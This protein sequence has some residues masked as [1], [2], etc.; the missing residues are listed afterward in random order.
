MVIRTPYRVLH[1]CSLAPH[2]HLNFCAP[3]SLIVKYYRL[4]SPL[5]YASIVTKLLTPLHLLYPSFPIFPISS[6]LTSS[7]SLI[8]KRPTPCALSPHLL[9]CTQI[10]TR[11]NGSITS[12]GGS[13]TA[14]CQKHKQNR[15][16]APRR[17]GRIHLP[18]P[19][20]PKQILTLL[21][22]TQPSLQLQGKIINQ[23]RSWRPLRYQTLSQ[24]KSRNHGNHL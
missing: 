9:V 14:R 19:Q 5:W 17:L 24:K 15:Y 3:T 6:W 20:P 4:L 23:Y 8:V 2:L 22:S 16:H 10:L 7:R 1:L 18:L 21:L 11:A 12:F 13:N